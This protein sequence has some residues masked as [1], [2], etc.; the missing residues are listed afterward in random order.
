MTRRQIAAA[1]GLM[2]VGSQLPLVVRELRWYV[3]SERSRCKALTKSG[4]RCARTRLDGRKYCRQHDPR[5]YQPWI[6]AA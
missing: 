4:A 6:K 5:Q 2:L 1:I 3:S